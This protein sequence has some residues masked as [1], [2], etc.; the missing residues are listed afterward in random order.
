M[1]TENSIT[2]ELASLLAGKGIV[3]TDWFSEKSGLRQLKLD[4][5]ATL[6]A[7]GKA[8]SQSPLKQSFMSEADYMRVIEKDPIKG[9]EVYWKET[10]QRVRYALNVSV[11]R[12][13]K[14]LEGIFLGVRYENLFVFGASYRGFIEAV[15]DSLDALKLAN[16]RL[17]ERKKNISLILSGKA[18]VLGTGDDIEKYLDER[19]ESALIHFSHARDTKGEEDTPLKSHKKKQF[20]EYLESVDREYREEARASYRELCQLTHP[21]FRSTFAF[22]V[23]GSNEKETNSSW[24]VGVA[25]DFLEIAKFTLKRKNVLANLCR[26]LLS[27]IFLCQEILKEL[28]YGDVHEPELGAVLNKKA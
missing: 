10:L 4:P 28:P 26:E 23:P 13:Q 17:R 9:L 22:V 3:K 6:K 20:H 27:Q 24:T 21:S 19:L 1:E 7:C 15:A 16:V 12:N 8:V 14:W 11:L 2:E 5:N 18:M 25:K